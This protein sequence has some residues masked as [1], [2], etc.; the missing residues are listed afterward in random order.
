MSHTRES[1][2]TLGTC[3]CNCGENNV[4]FR[5]Y[6]SSKEEQEKLEE[7]KDQL[8]NELAGVEERIQELKTK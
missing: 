2:K 6:V 4:L 3:G 8:K 5:R 7:Y 1:Q